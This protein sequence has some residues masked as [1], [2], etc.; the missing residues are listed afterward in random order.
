MQ[1]GS[2]FIVFLFLEVTSEVGIALIFHGPKKTCFFQSLTL[3]NTLLIFS[4][5]ARIFLHLRRW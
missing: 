4:F 5:D 3:F 2:C 1:E